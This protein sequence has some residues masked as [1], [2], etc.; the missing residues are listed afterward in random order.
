[1]MDSKMKFKH[2]LFFSFSVLF[3]FLQV[4]PVFAESEKTGMKKAC[5]ML[6]ESGSLKKSSEWDVRFKIA[7]RW[8]FRAIKNKEIKRFLSAL[9]A[10]PL[11]QKPAFIKKIARQMGLKRCRFATHMRL[12]AKVEEKRRKKRE[13]AQQ[14]AK[15]KQPVR[16]PAKFIRPTPFPPTS[17]GRIIRKEMR[18]RRK[19]FLRCR[20]QL[21]WIT[22][23][24]PAWYHLYMTIQ[25]N[26]RVS[27]LQATGFRRNSRIV[28]C[29]RALG[30]TLRFPVWPAK[31]TKK[32]K[33]TIILE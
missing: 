20:K 32:L 18:V 13:R 17:L 8:A 28:R 23:K 12:F 25:P 16:A 11:K 31:K 10:M 1:M 26:G 15:K 3:F 33:V 30:K 4:S 27:R 2:T 5:I 21:R 9:D 6:E 7:Y 24:L 19:D 29:Y 14:L 22:R